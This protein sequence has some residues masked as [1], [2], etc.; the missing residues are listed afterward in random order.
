MLSAVFVSLF[1]FRLTEALQQLNVLDETD[2]LSEE[3][4]SASGRG[5]S[6]MQSQGHS[7]T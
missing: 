1:F 2:N 6:H 4:A 5:H 7:D 3:S